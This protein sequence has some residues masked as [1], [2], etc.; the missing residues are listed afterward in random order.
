MKQGDF[1]KISREGE[2][3]WC[4]LLD[5]H[6]TGHWRARINNHLITNK[7]QFGQEI[8]IAPGEEILALM[9]SEE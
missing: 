9:P 8:D 7:L 6:E 4:E 1:V 3:F 5:K 2:R